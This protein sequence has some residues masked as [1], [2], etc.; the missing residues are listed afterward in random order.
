MEVIGDLPLLP[1]KA[2]REKRLAEVRKRLDDLERAEEKIISDLE[3][4]GTWIPRRADVRPQ[5][6]LEVVA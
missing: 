3:L 5:I 4:A 6:V 1:D 2:T